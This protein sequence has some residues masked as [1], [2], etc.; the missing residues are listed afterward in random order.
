MDVSEV[1]HKGTSKGCKTQGF[2]T[3][4]RIRPPSGEKYLMLKRALLEHKLNT[5]CE[6]AKCPNMG[7]CWSRGSATFMILGTICT[8]NCR[9]CAVEK[10]KEGEPLDPSE[11]ARIAEA[12]KGTGLRYVV[13]TSVDRDDLPDGGAQHFADCIRAIK[14]LDDNIFVETLIPDFRGDVSSLRT[15]V[16]AHPDVVG[17]NMETT[18]EFQAIVRD[19]RAGYRISL[20]VL[21]NLKRISSTIYTKSSL[22]LGLGE[23]EEMVLKTMGDLRDAGVDIITLGQ[24]LQPSAGQFEVREYLSPDKYEYYEKKA[25]EM[26]FLC[27]VSGPLVRSSYLADT[28]VPGIKRYTG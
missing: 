13:L 17:H 19:R 12:V 6:G 3:K 15:I 8:R 22:M 7:E 23:R 11:P 18:E 21:R 14:S 4:P 25:K 24:Y 26:G 16:D 9:F 1:S 20:E 27:V 2:M 5:V 28:F 10:G